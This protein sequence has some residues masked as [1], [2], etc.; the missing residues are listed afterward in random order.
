MYKRQV[1]YP[2]KNGRIPPE[3]GGYFMKFV[4][5]D[6][7]GTSDIEQGFRNPPACYGIVP[8]FWW[9]GDPLTKERLSFELEKLSGHDLCGLQVNYAHSAKGGRAYG[10]TYPSDPPL[11]SDAWWELVGWMIDEGKKYGFSVSLSDYTLGIPGQGNF[12]DDMIRENPDIHGGWLR[13]V[14]FPIPALA[15]RRYTTGGWYRWQGRRRRAR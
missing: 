12:A 6:R 10:L 14:S 3:V 7:E 4:K 9:V 15:A 13:A 5:P 8:F 2:P 1:R 11:Y